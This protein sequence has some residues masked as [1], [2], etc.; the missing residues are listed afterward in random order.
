M[1]PSITIPMPVSIPV[2]MAGM[3]NSV[4]PKHNPKAMMPIAATV[5]P[6]NIPATIETGIDHSRLPKAI[7]A[8]PEARP[9]VT[10]QLTSPRIK[11]G[12]VSMVYTPR[13][14]VLATSST[15]CYSDRQLAAMMNSVM[16]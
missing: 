11:Y 7:T 16:L 3:C 1:D 8:V 5:I 15:S 4:M 10:L 2:I 6:S 9:T 13:G 12:R 14:C